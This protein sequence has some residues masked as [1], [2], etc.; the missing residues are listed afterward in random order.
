MLHYWNFLYERIYNSRAQV[1]DQNV[2]DSLVIQPAYLWLWVIRYCELL[3]A[4]LLMALCYIAHF[5]WR[6]NTISHLTLAWKHLM[7]RQ[8]DSMWQQKP[9]LP[10]GSLICLEFC[11]SVFSCSLD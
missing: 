8:Q 4:P 11:L 1:D 2:F 6:T 3:A 7:A 10:A 9:V 5:S